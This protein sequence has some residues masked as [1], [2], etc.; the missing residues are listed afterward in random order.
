MIANVFIHKNFEKF[1]TFLFQIC[2]VPDA[3]REEGAIP[4]K[5]KV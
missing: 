3:K 4:N 5:D 1:K 2:E